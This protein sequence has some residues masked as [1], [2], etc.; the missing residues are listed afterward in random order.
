M[1]LQLLSVRK[2]IHARAWSNGFLAGGGGTKTAGTFSAMIKMLICTGV[3]II[4][5]DSVTFKHS[6]RQTYKQTL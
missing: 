5:L 3:N 6:F 1:L 4:G 2:P